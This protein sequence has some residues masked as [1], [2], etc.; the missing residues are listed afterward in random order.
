MNDPKYFKKVRYIKEVER[1]VESLEEYEERVENVSQK[2]L[3]TVL[4]KVLW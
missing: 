3:K 2:R 1:W 4:R